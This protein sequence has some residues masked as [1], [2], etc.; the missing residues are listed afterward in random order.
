MELNAEIPTRL[1]MDAAIAGLPAGIYALQA[2]APGADPYETPPATQWFV[3]S[4]LGIA[5]MSGTDGLHVFVRS[6]ASAEAQAGVTVTL[7]SRANR[8]LGTGTTDRAGYVHF[9]PG[10][11]QGQAGAAPALVTAR[12]ADT[13]IAFLSLTGPDFDLSD[14]G[15]E[16][17]EPAPPIDLFLATDRGAY[18]A[19]ETIRAT[20]LARDDRADDPL[21]PL[22]RLTVDAALQARMAAPVRSTVRPHGDR[23][24][25][26]L[27]VADHRTGAIL[28]H[29]GSPAFTDGARADYV[30]TALAPRSPDSTLKPL[31]HGLAFGDGLAHPET[32]AEDRPTAFGAYRPSNFDG[33]Y[34]GTVSLR[35]ALQSSLNIPA[36]AL[37]E[38]LGPARVIAGL[39]RAGVRPALPDGQ[40]DLAIALGGLGVTLEDL[41][42]LYA[43]V[44]NGGLA[45]PLHWKPDSEDSPHSARVLGP[46]AAW[47]VA[48]ILRGVPAPPTAPQGRIAFKTGASY[49]HRDAWAIGFDGAFVVGVWIGRPDGTPVPGAF[50]ADLTAPLLS[51]AFARM[52]AEPV[53][54]PP[55]PPGALIVANADLPP[56]LKRLGRP[57]RAGG[58]G[59]RIAFPPDGADLGPDMGRLPVKLQGRVPPFTV[60]ADGAPLATGL[61]RRENTLTAPGPGF[62]T[63]SVIYAEGHA[64]RAEIRIRP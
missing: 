20:A 26:A 42:R 19:D 37:A 55:P 41:T 4:D 13:D 43:A 16:G 62:V 45:V 53:P 9:A 40:P 48:D 18:R 21:A 34:R 58:D 5:T 25:A 59:P 57:A 22:H 24:S 11:T 8:V 35:A 1:P 28:A 64:T 50:G 56:P 44:A 54:L 63:L 10:L 12:V 30:D 36:I 38:A 15:V 51:D 6:L 29:V 14:R 2:A 17:R 60:L 47:N 7:L 31:I 27:V 32:L 3:L 61:F 33:R 39:R 46:E 52:S 23:L 49:G